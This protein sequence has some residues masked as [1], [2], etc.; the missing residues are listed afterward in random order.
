MLNLPGQLLLDNSSTPERSSSSTP[1]KRSWLSSLPIDDF[2]VNLL[3][4]KGLVYVN[5]KVP[6]SFIMDQ[7][8]EQLDCVSGRVIEKFPTGLAALSSLKGTNLTTMTK[9]SM[10][11]AITGRN[12]DRNHDTNSKN[13]YAHMYKGHFWRLVGSH[14]LPS[15]AN[16]AT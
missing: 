5:K 9:S 16:G 8:V 10:A 12:H 4:E 15:W 14:A 1:N 2:V 3:S 13:V 6:A 7:P 11:H